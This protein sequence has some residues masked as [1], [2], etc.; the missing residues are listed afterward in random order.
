MSPALGQIQFLRWSDDPKPILIIE[1]FVC[2]ELLGVG[3]EEGN[4][5]ADTQ[6]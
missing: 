1:K 3:D 4:T 5:E 2:W 6:K